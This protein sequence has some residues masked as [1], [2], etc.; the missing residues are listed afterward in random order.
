MAATV[1]SAYNAS[2]TGNGWRTRAAGVGAAAAAAAVVWT[3]AVQLLGVH[4]VIR[5][6]HSAPQTIGIG[7]VVGVSLGASLAAWALLAVLER[8]M[9]SARTI[10]TRTAVVVLLLSLSM[11]ATAATTVSTAVTLGAMHVAVATM[12]IAVLRRGHAGVALDS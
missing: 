10:W 1:A 3:V 2:S 9:S 5:F 4:L 11:P 6:G 12:L 8:R 7:L